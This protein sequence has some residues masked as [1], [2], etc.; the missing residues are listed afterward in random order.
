MVKVRF[1]GGKAMT[2]TTTEPSDN[3]SDMLFLSSVQK[4]INHAKRAKKILIEAP[5]YQEGNRVFTFT[6]DKPLEW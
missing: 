5:F 4:F 3:S 2:F 1:D 6:V